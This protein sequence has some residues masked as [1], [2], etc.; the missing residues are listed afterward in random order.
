MHP[1]GQAKAGHPTLR[2]GKAEGE[3]DADLFAYKERYSTEYS[4]LVTIT[5]L[6]ATSQTSTRLN[7]KLS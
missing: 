6:L 3:I 1:R 4:V 5:F 7:P 2:S